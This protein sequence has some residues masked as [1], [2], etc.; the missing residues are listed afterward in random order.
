[1][2]TPKTKAKNKPK[3]KAETTS[4][5]AKAR[6]EKKAAQRA[7]LR[8]TGRSPHWFGVPRWIVGAV[9]VGVIVF[10]WTYQPWSV[11]D[12]QIRTIV[13]DLRTSA[14]YQAPGAPPL[15]N[16]VRARQVV[17]DRPIVVVAM[18]DTPLPPATTDEGDD[19]AELGFCEQIADQITNDYVLLF[20]T[21]HRA[22]GGKDTYEAA[23]CYGP[24]FPVPDKKTSTGSHDD[25]LFGFDFGL[26]L[27]F[28]NS[29]QF[30]TTATNLTPDIEQFALAYDD[31]VGEY[32]ST[33]PRRGAIPD[34]LAGSDIA[35]DSLA[36]VAGV[37]LL[38]ALLRLAA[39][40]LGNQQAK[41][42][43]LRRRRTELGLRL[44][45]IADTVLHPRP[46][47][48]AEEA[49]AQEAIAQRYV[50]LLTRTEQASTPAALAEAEG[51]A[52]DLANAATGREGQR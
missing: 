4:A 46:V 7:E 49:R 25:Q 43:E 34:R 52:A 37:V 45:E 31:E 38:F 13:A 6:A 32:Y 44:N 21:S 12:A 23:D 29:S 51:E 48:T 17:G 15:L 41:D 3:N 14:I 8:R 40:R 35:L 47:D 18:P 33:P 36:I 2:T 5:T 1:V 28:H 9:V 20:A 50:A 26:S 42:A 10:L 27:D 11:P 39:R 16:A 22:D 30:V 24:D 19:D